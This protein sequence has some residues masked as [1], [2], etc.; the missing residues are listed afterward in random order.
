[1]MA[2]VSTVMAATSIDQSLVVVF[3]S[4]SFSG[5]KILYLH[6][7]HRT[8]RDTLLPIY[9][10]YSQPFLHYNLWWR[11][12]RSTF[13]SWLVQF[14]ERISRD[15][16]NSRSLNQDFK[17]ASAPCVPL[18]QLKRSFPGIRPNHM[19]SEVENDSL[20]NRTSTCFE[21][22][23]RFISTSCLNLKFLDLFT[24]NNEKNILTLIGLCLIFMIWYFRV[25]LSNEV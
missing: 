14:K 17:S 24:H 25:S 21:N 13:F 15:M 20:H 10:N 12:C 16:I 7:S 3:N 5:F 1:M 6:Q 11:H 9:D 4:Y 18:Y 19:R 2:T 22:L 8:I 23:R